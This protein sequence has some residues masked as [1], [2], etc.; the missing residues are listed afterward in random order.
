M[1][2]PAQ[3][4]AH[5]SDPAALN[6]YFYTKEVYCSESMRMALP[7]DLLASVARAKGLDEDLYDRLAL[8]RACRPSLGGAGWSE[9]AL[10]KLDMEAEAEEEAK[11]KADADDN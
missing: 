1:R 10:F 2:Q 7:P 5:L 11:A 8:F 4:T 3:T 9:E 6:F